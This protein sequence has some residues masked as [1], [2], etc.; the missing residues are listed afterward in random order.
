MLNIIQQ[1]Q[2]LMMLNWHAKFQM[3][4]I[5]LLMLILVFKISFN[6]FHKLKRIQNYHPALKK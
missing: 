3:L 4:M 2:Q 6:S 5:L 1:K